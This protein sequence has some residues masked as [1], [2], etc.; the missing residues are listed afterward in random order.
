VKYI[1]RE[2]LIVL[3]KARRTKPRLMRD[4]RFV[5]EEVAHWDK[6]EM[7]AVFTKSANE[8]VLF[9]ELDDELVL[10][11]FER[12]KRIIDSATG[13]SKSITCDFCKTWQRGSNA[14]IICFPLSDGRT[15]GYLCCADLDCSLHVRNL[16][17]QSSL[18]RT[19]LHED[20]TTEGRIVR[21]KK[22]LHTLIE[23]CS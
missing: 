21:L 8:G 17:P 23:Q 20:I 22:S 16:T 14:A 6:R 3:L 11:P 19:Q 9:I 2:S 10:L 13:R 12:G 18:S 1:D 4:I 5:P 15:K 7:L